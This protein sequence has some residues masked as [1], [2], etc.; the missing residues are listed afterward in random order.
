MFKI[1]FTANS[2]KLYFFVCLVAIEFLAT[3]ITVHISLVESMWD[4]SNH[5][6]AF[7]V[8]YI[9]MSLGYYK[10][11]LQVK[12]AILLAFGLQIE[13]VQD[14]TGRSLFSGL[15]ILADSIGVLIGILTI[16]YLKKFTKVFSLVRCDNS[17]DN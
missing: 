1:L 3:T 5:F 13:I 11:S 8:L 9:F 2:F 16:L 7:F 6:I 4:K 12:V 15:D 14:L 10:L 17:L